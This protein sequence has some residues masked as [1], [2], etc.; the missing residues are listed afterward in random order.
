MYLFCGCRGAYTHYGVPLEVRDQLVACSCDV[1]PGK[2][3]QAIRLD[4]TYFHV[5]HNITSSGN[6]FFPTG[7][8]VVNTYHS[9]I[10]K[11]RLEGRKFKVYP[12]FLAKGRGKS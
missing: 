5:L 10:L 8:A 9:R 11:V 7:V 6:I 2:P 4:S 12:S 3:A 1:D